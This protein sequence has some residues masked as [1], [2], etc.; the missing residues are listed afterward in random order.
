MFFKPATPKTVAFSIW[1]RAVTR[2][3]IISAIKEATAELGRVPSLAMLIRDRKVDRYDLVRFFGCYRE[4]LNACGLEGKGSG[5]RI[6]QD[7]L[8]REWVEITRSLGKIPTIPEYEEH[9]RHSV[10]PL[11]TRCHTW[12]QVPQFVLDYIRVGRL[13]GNWEDVVDIVLKS[14]KS[15]EWER[16]TSNTSHGLILKPRIYAEKLF[17]GAPLLPMVVTYEPTNEAGVVVLFASL[18]RELGFTITHVQMEFPDC[19]VMR[20]VERGRW[21]RLRVE[22]EFESRNFAAHGHDPEGCDLIVCWR[23]NWEDCPLEV[24]ELKRVVEGIARVG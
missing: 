9:S 12:R 13:E 6:T 11:L 17:Y 8:F 19:E 7:A 3:E 16:R 20:E 5:Y 24:L 15:T 22:F 2:E 23:H 10:R 18:A 1:R 14:L 4:A 21:Q